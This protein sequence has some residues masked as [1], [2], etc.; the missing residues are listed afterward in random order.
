MSAVLNWISDNRSLLIILAAGSVLF[1]LLR[2][3]ASPVAGLE[4][5]QSQVSRG[6]PTLVHVFSNT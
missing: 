1:M 6:Q 5:Y 2:N 3:T 4:A